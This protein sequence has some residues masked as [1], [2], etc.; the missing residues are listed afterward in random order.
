MVNIQLWDSTIEEVHEKKMFDLRMG[1]G[2]A[3]AYFQ[4]LKEE[5]KLAG[6][7]SDE[8]EQGAMVKAV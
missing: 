1:N 6:L 3:T 5:A 8:R 7:R 2:A 4:V